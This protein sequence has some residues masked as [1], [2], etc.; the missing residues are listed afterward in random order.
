MTP[1]AG[2]EQGNHTEVGAACEP[3]GGQHRVSGGDGQ[4]LLPPPVPGAPGRNPTAGFRVRSETSEAIPALGEAPSPGCQL[5]PAAAETLG[6]P[7]GPLLK[8]SQVPRTV[9]INARTQSPNSQR[10]KPV[11]AGGRETAKRWELD[12]EVITS[13]ALGSF[14]PPQT[15]VHSSVHPPW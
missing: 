5:P 10:G 7:G 4:S 3:A 2:A 1:P 13:P 6:F 15:Q 14:S 8:P 12:L 11:T 9:L